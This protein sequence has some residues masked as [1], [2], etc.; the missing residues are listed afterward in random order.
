MTGGTDDR[1]PQV[2]RL[3]ATAQDALQRHL[4]LD[5]DVGAARG[6][7][8]TP[9]E[10][11]LEQTPAEVE[12]ESAENV[13]EIDAREQILLREAL[14]PGEAARVVLRTFL[15]VRQNRVGRRDLLESLLGAGFLAAIRMML[16]RELAE[17]VL[18][19]RRIGSPRYAEDFV[20]VALGCRR[21]GS[22]AP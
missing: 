7:G 20:V 19:G 17:C 18:D 21:D 12:V 4:E 13:V 9:A 3:L 16:E 2:Q 8:R 6:P 22:P 1:T 10:K 15:R 14:D 11:A 5:F